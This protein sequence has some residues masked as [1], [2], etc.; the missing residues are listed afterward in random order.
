[1]SSIYKDINTAV[2][3]DYRTVFPVAALLIMLI[4][5]LLLRSVVAP[6]YLIASVGLG[7]V[8]PS[9]PPSGSSRT[10]RDTRG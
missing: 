4:L 2:N 9:A 7:S 6:W 5:G 3:H 8:P 10:R 1:M